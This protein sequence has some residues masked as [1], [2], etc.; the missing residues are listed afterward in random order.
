[1]P[2]RSLEVL[3]KSGWQPSELQII[4]IAVSLLEILQYLSDHNLVHRDISPG[5]ILV[6]QTGVTVSLV[7]FGGGLEVWDD[8]VN[9]GISLSSIEDET[10]H[11]PKAGATAP[12]LRSTI[13]GTAGFMAPE[14]T[15]GAVSPASDAY[16]LGATLLYLASQGR[17]PSVGH[18]LRVRVPRSIKDRRLR[19]LLE[20]LLEPIPED[21][22]SPTEA[23]ELLSSSPGQGVG[24]AVLQQHGETA[25]LQDERN[26][27]GTS[28][29]ASRP[30]TGSRLRIVRRGPRL[31]IEIPPARFSADALSMAT[32]AVA[33]NAFVGVW[34]VSAVAGGGILF[35]LFSLP[36]W[37]AGFKL[38][39]AAL[40]AQ[41]LRYGY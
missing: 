27:P 1:M 41:C 29:V 25:A 21:R 23:L 24:P 9:G 5:N 19:A 30:P 31:E 34:T 15:I 11:H 20:S 28:E 14:A 6:D 12:P 26:G 35:G 38:S 22:L 18:R 39:K 4:Q 36:F 7:D 37:A 13:L 32:F 2:G 40:A 10:L 3:T 33:W 17:V 8:S 16:G